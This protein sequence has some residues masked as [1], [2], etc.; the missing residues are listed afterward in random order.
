MYQ[1]G[2]L[3]KGFWVKCW[4]EE[5]VFFG[6]K[7]C[8]F[9]FLYFFSNELLKCCGFLNNMYKTTEPDW[10]MK[11]T[12]YWIWTKSKI[13]RSSESFWKVKQFYLLIFHVYITFL[14][15]D[16]SSTF[17]SQWRYKE[18]VGSKSVLISGC[19]ALI[20]VGLR[21]SA[22]FTVSPPGFLISL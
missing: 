10:K 11:A 22:Y 12:T 16:S 6:Y 3:I 5:N 1:K 9:I 14:K 20:F 7:V 13:K 18:G 4:K 8:F 19:T 21:W 15:S 2:T 17:L